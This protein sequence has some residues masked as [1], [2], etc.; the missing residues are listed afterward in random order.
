M[1]AVALIINSEFKMTLERI[2]FSYF[3]ILFRHYKD[4]TEKSQNLQSE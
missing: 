3:K 2:T 1:N 4:K